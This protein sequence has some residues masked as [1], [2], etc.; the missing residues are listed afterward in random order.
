MLLT[1]GFDLS[2]DLFSE[3]ISQ[4]FPVVKF[5]QAFKQYPDPSVPPTMHET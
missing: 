3:A 4:S 5:L 2:C 1:Q